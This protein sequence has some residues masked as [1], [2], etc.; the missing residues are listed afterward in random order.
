MEHNGYWT[1]FAAMAIEGTGLPIPMEFLFLP[2]GFA[3]TQGR[4]NLGLV[5][6]VSTLGGVF[7]NLIGYLAGRYCGPSVIRRLSSLIHLREDSLAKAS[8]WFQSHGGRT[9]FL[10]RFLGFIRAPS[11]LSAGMVGMDLVKYLFY[12]AL[13]GVVW[14]GFWAVAAWLFGSQLPAVLGR[15][16]PYFGALIAALAAGTV[17]F[18]YTFRKTV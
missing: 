10:S 2:A 1:L 17:W 4:M 11:I 8:C 13:G 14:N 7:G 18:H 3:V 16:Y 12:S 5:V 6:L 15:Y 9:I